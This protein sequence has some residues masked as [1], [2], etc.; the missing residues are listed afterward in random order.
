M[1]TAPVE[2]VADFP[3]G[4]ERLLVDSTGVV[5]VWVNG[6]ATRRDGRELE[7]VAAGRLLRS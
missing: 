2:R 3:A 7:G 4:A 6:V 5:H 1:G